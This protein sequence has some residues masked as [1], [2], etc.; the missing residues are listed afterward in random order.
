MSRSSVWR[1]LLTAVL[2]TVAV[3]LLGEWA[4]RT[5]VESPS[6]AIP[7]A[8]LRWRYAPHV[9]VV[10]SGEGFSVQHTNSLGLISPELRTPRP[11]RRAILLGDS[12][13]EALQVHQGLGFAAIVARDVPGVELVNAGCSG[14]SPL[15]CEEWATLHGPPLAPDVLVLE[16]SEFNVRE[17]LQP[18][19]PGRIA[20][21]PTDADR[22]APVPESRMHALTRTVMQHSALV[23]LGVRR[24]NLLIADQQARLSRRFREAAVV[25]KRAGPPPPDPRLPALLDTVCTRTSR[26][27]PRFVLVYIPHLEYF[28]PGAPL[29]DSVACAVVHEVAARHGWPLVDAGPGFREEFRRTGQPVHGFDN[30][31]KGTGHINEAGHR[32]VGAALATALREAAR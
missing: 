30:S 4:V 23:T 20:H 17:L 7:T 28:T 16:L 29:S 12:F 26:L 32:V 15:D 22:D 31:V 25:A 5:R 27:A 11:A 9:R 24:M 19:V 14:Y 2:G 10:H 13:A 21:P 3:L 18:A 1:F 8:R 6:M